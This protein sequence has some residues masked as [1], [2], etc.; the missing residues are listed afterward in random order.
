[1]FK[2]IFFIFLFMASQSCFSSMHMYGYRKREGLMTDGKMHIF[3]CG[4]GNPEVQLQYFRKPSCLA[5]IANNHFIIIDAGEGGVQNLA[6]MGLPL[7]K[8]DSVF[9]T[10]WHSDHFSGI[11][12]LNNV[13]WL[14]GR[15]KALDIYGPKGVLEATKSINT[16]YELDAR[17]RISNRKGLLSSESRKLSAHELSNQNPIEFS[18]V[19]SKS[20]FRV[21]PFF[22]DHS[23]VNPA[24]GYEINFKRCKIVISGDTKLVKQLRKHYQSADLLIHEVFSASLGAHIKNNIS[25]KNSTNKD[26]AFYEQTK[27]YHTDSIALSKMADDSNVKNLFLTHLTPAIPRDA[28]IEK[29]FILGMKNTF[30]NPI[31]IANDRDEIELEMVN[32]VCRL[33]H[34]P[35]NS[36]LEAPIKLMS[37]PMKEK[38]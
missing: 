36:K 17:Y 6:V 15:Q 32:G 13:S 3:F 2:C 12:Y 20:I 9:V 7:Q 4:T 19:K 21:Q 35:S 5:L 25:S 29:Q 30:K 18:D 14:A 23:P 27:S 38:P 16:L 31:T 22:V 8:I 1:M 26:K 37:G 33:R 28:T 24:L 10:H 34:I 11:P